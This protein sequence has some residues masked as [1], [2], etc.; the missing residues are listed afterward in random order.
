MRSAALLLGAAAFIVARLV[1]GC[2]G[3]SGSSA[4]ADAGGSA[5][6]SLGGDSSAA[7]GEGYDVLA[8]LGT[9]A[10]NPDEDAACVASCPAQEP[11]PGAPC[12]T[13]CAY[14]V[15]AGIL[16]SQLYS[17]TGNGFD[18]GSRQ[19]MTPL[20]PGCPAT[21]GSIEAAVEAGT[22]CN[23]DAPP[24]AYGREVCQCSVFSIGPDASTGWSCFDIAADCPASPPLEG[25]ACSPSG[26]QCSYGANQCAAR[27]FGFFLCK[28]GVWVA[29]PP[30][31]CP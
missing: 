14:P 5:D 31:P 18:N 8:S 22:S 20:G 25:T 9:D 21:P 29:L 12:T 28:C 15:D 4:V 30:S 2:G 1:V 19:C 6:A 13:G 7:D 16:C 24:C 11:E 23:Q 27:G 10:P 3:G 17:C 26:H